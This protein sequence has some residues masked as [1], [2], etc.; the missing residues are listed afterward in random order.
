MVLPLCENGRHNWTGC[1]P[2][3]YDLSL[4]ALETDRSGNELYS[5]GSLLEAE[6]DSG[7]GALDPGAVVCRPSKGVGYSPAS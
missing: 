7:P 6:T 3:A 4:P 2:Y 1:M 5:S